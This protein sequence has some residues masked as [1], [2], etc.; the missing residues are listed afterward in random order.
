GALAQEPTYWLDL[1]WTRLAPLPCDWPATPEANL[2]GTARTHTVALEAE[3]TEALLHEVPAAYGTQINDVL[4]TALAQT[5]ATWTGTP[6][7]LLDLEGHGREALF[8]DVDLTRT[9]GWFTTIFPVLL[10]LAEMDGPGAALR[11]VKEQPRRI[12][13]H[14][15]GY[16]LLRYS[17]DDARA[18]QLQALPQAQVSFNYLGQLDPVLTADALFAPARESAGPA[19]SPRNPRPYLL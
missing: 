3:E 16:G 1:P 17:S 6:T 10:D 15:L 14:G 11:T 13:R 8:E 2:V 12:P 18:Q 9:V 7:L 19:N 5:L 4:L